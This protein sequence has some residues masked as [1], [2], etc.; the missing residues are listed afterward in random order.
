M[1]PKQ[2]GKRTRQEMVMAILSHCIE[3]MT[4][5]RLLQNANLNHKTLDRYL[6]ML[7]RGGHIEEVFIP[8]TGPGNSF[9]LRTTQKGIVCLQLYES[10]RKLTFNGAVVDN[11]H[12]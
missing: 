2:K 12:L 7:K 4:E 10:L 11:E 6:R 1:G 5:T 3:P 9:L 8:K